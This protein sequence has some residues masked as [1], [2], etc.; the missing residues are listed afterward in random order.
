MSDLIRVVLQPENLVVKPGE[1]L[2][3]VIEVQNAGRVVDAYSIE[4]LGLEPGWYHLASGSVSLFPGDGEPVNLT[5]SPPAGSEA[6]ARSY[7]FTIKVFSTA[8]PNEETTVHPV[9][10]VEPDYS[11]GVDIHPEKV[12]GKV[13]SYNISISNTGNAP[14]TFDFEGSDPEGFCRC[15]FRPSPATVAPGEVV[16]VAITVRPT[17]RPFLEPP[18][19]YALTFVAAPQQTTDRP[20]LRAELDALP[21]ARKWYFPVAAVLLVILA[22]IAYSVNWF[23]VERNDLTYLRAEKW[24]DVTE[25]QQTSHGLIYPFEFKLESRTGDDRPALVPIKIRG[26]V[27]WPATGEVPPSVAVILRDPPGNC[28]GPKIVD[29]TGGPFQFSVFKDAI[30]CHFINYQRLLLDNSNPE[31][32][33]PA[34]YVSGKSLVKYCV[35]DLQTNP[36]VKFLRGGELQTTERLTESHSHG[37][38]PPILPEAGTDDGIWTVYL[39]NPHPI[40]HWP[41]AP[42]VTIKL[43]AATGEE[44]GGSKKDENYTV[45]ELKAPPPARL[46]PQVQCVWDQESE[47][48]LEHGVVFVR[49]LEFLPRPR[50]GD[51]GSEEELKLHPTSCPKD[52]EEGLNQLRWLCGD[53]TWDEADSESGRA[54]ASSVFIILRSSLGDEARCWSRFE[55]HTP[56][57]SESTPFFFDLIDGGLPCR[58]ELTKPKQKLWN[59]MNWITFLPSRYHGVQPLVKFCAH[60]GGQTLFGKSTA[61]PQMDTTSWDQNNT[62][63][64]TIYIVNPS[65]FPE[66]PR[67]TVKVKGD[68]N[69]KVTL[70]EL[71]NPTL[72][73]TPLVPPGS[74]SC[75]AP[76]LG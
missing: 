46:S 14:L 67:V 8:S 34:V 9:L 53:I 43:K 11:F 76:D 29:R 68:N 40:D 74:G 71:A 54:T 49:N 69:W 45:V 37:I 16:D 18:R 5:L 60:T 13:G 57:D 44:G 20:V 48:L 6:V 52:D 55:E 58:K 72:G 26:D 38:P 19:T 15:S 12:T 50:V 2:Q 51:S 1:Q 33:T 70:R 22:L 32:L 31:A 21:R 56:P 59:L 27:T 65:S 10:E 7:E 24:D 41:V 66:A 35:R 73:D 3:T 64:W 25:P 17:R 36:V 42:E 39:V 30:P 23:F 28:W 63:G 75:P 61:I 47:V 62:L 4:V